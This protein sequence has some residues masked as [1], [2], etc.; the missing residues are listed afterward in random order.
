MAGLLIPATGG[1]LTAGR[2]PR[3]L[4]REVTPDIARDTA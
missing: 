1:Y 4:M 3:D 2:W